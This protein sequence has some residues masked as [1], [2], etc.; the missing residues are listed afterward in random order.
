MQ[1][2]V[3]T[4]LSL[5]LPALQSVA[6]AQSAFA[7]DCADVAVES[8]T[9]LAS[10]T[11][12]SP[13]ADMAT[14]SITLP[15]AAAPPAEPAGKSLDSQAPSPAPPDAN[16][17]NQDIPYHWLDRTHEVLYNTLWHSAEHV[18]RWFGSVED[19]TV[20][21]QMYGSIAPALLYTQ[22]DRLR[23]QIRFN[24]NIPLPQLNDRFHAF[25]GRFDPNEFIT[26]QNEPS[27]AFPRTYG[28]P[29]EDQTLLG[30]GY[31]QADKPQEGGRFDAGTG[32]RVALPMDPYVKGSYIY[33]RGASESGLLSAR[34]TLFWQHSDGAGE[35]TR[36]DMERIYDVHWLLRYTASATR[37]Q[38]S[39]GL[40]GYS[41]VFILH[42]LPSRRAVAFEMGVDGQTQAPVPLHDYGLKVAYRKGILRQWLIMETRASIDWPK[43][44]TYQQR[45]ASLGVGVG[46]EML[47]GTNT[48]LARPVTF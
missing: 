47:F 7:S 20:Y 27:G 26:E 24:M 29:T 13:P 6:R 14:N 36:L 32:I 38:H 2:S 48:F 17:P 46:F 43:D 39:M 23:A 22:Y 15:V 10:P 21:K 33:Q 12:T 34:E 18:D 44:Y 4:M 37:S 1:R 11:Q 41:S 8:S 28:P 30:I 3:K 40:R 19:D 16:E 31:H 45:T 5:L 42:D 9:E 35:T 25:V